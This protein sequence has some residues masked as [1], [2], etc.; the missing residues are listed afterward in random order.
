MRLTRSGN[1]RVKIIIASLCTAPLLVGAI[2]TV[3]SGGAGASGQLAADSPVAPSPG[4][5]LNSGEF[6][7]LTMIVPQRP[8]VDGR[9]GSDKPAR[10]D[11]PVQGA[12]DGRVRR[13]AGPTRMPST[14]SRAGSSP[15]TAAPPRISPWS[16][17]TVGS[18]GRC[19]PG[20]ARSSPTTPAAAG[21]TWPA[22]PGASILGPVLNGKGGTGRIK[23]TDKGRYDGD[24][25][26][27]RAVGP[28][29]IIP[30]VW[31]EFGADGN[32]D[33]FR[34]PNNVYDA[35]TTVA[36]YLCSEGDDLKRP[37]DLVAS[38]LRYQH[39]KDF[40]A[41][42]LRWMRVYSKSAVLVPNAKGNLPAPK[43]TGNAERKVDPRDVPDVPDD[44]RPTTATPTSR[45]R[46]RR[47]GPDDSRPSRTPARRRRPVDADAHSRPTSRTDKPTRPRRRRRPPRRPRRRL[48]HRRRL[49]RPSDTP[50]GSPC[51]TETNPTPCTQGSGSHGYGGSASERRPPR[52]RR[53]NSD[54]PPRLR[55]AV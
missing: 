36:V 33:G 26:W 40:V 35:V 19:W 51:A 30:G 46:R 2:V 34:N 10:A 55:S 5:G 49:R 37:R 16:A 48:P 9:I 11:V 45:G 29:Q 50:T 22:P 8:G 12:T 41:T 42:V 15:P 25:A 4:A 6:D 24:L 47:A 38:L 17:R 28:M 54:D 23:D 20:S 14:A 3:A 21:S 18:P 7:E 53:R 52:A 31:S 13:P 39:S 44:K 27:D 43:P 1:R 32:G